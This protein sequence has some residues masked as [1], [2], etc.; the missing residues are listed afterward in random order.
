MIIYIYIYYIYFHF[1][2]GTGKSDPP[3]PGPSQNGPLSP[4]PGLSL[5]V[6]AD[7]FKHQHRTFVCW[8]GLSG[9]LCIG[10]AFL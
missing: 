1:S 6:V 5:S 7:F 10:N 9:S 2:P 3:S 8:A 4:G